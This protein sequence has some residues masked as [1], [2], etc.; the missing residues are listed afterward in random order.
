MEP[1]RGHPLDIDLLGVALGDADAELATEVADHLD[2]CLL[3]R[4]RM[5]RLRR[6]DAVPSAPPSGVD[7]PSVS[8]AAL[9]VLD[10]AVR[11]DALAAGQVWLAGS[12]RRLLVW[13]R[14]VRAD[15]VV[16]HPVTMDVDGVDDTALLV[17]DLPALGGPA[18]VVT[19]IVGTVPVRTLVSY[20]GDL[21]VGE[22][23]ERLRAAA[24]AG[25]AELDLPTGR[26]ITGPTDERL[27]LRQLIADDLAALDAVEEDDED[28]GT[29]DDGAD[30]LQVAA[31]H[32]YEALR[33]DFLARRGRGCEVRK[34]AGDLALGS[35]AESTGC[36]LVARI[37]EL[38]SSVLLVTGEGRLDWAVEN[39][40]DASKLLRLA[41][42]G[43]LA[44]AEPVDPFTTCLFE[45]RHLH[46]ALELPRAVV[47]VGPRPGWGPKPMVKAL[48]DYL[49]DGVFAVEPVGGLSPPSSERNLLP[50]LRSNARQSV[51]G[52]RKGRAQLTKNTALKSLKKAD[53]DALAKA[54]NAAA[55][56]DDL[57]DLIE[58]ITER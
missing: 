35:F 5:A 37:T 30:A 42:A 23:V 50:Y 46:P 44:V 26:P 57:L 39:P 4:V 24:A 22:E 12:S 10:D 1:R 36:V 27:E 54:L 21:V 48:F 16:A 9:A 20:V 8:P 51:D 25:T 45:E 7:H 47:P 29:G 58:R 15:R 43:T 2:T 13:V 53:A 19:S 40:H 33:A 18:A 34:P 11:P 55:S 41:G 6:S 49:E 38:T 17:D 31:R 32:M 52:L 28:G 56:L 14:A 3:C